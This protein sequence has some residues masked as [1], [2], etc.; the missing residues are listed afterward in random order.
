MG[1]SLVFSISV[2]DSTDGQREKIFVVAGFLGDSQDWFEV[3]RLWEKR[4]KEDGLSYF[5]ATECFGLTGQFNELV[6]NTGLGRPEKK[7]VNHKVH[8][9][10]KW[11]CGRWV[12]DVPETD[13]HDAIVLGSSD[14][15]CRC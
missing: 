8:R 15:G 3:E 12:S 1:N 7:A 14:A 10:S 6:R 5:R 4:V 9:T 11:C 13:Q 2:D